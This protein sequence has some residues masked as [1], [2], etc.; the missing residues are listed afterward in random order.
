MKNTEPKKVDSCSICLSTLNKAYIE[1]GE[2]SPVEGGE[3][4]EKDCCKPCNCR[5]K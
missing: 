4:T 1:F 2:V 5:T 3:K